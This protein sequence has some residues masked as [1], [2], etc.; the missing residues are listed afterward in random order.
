MIE[1]LIEFMRR[2]PGMVARLL[3][4]HEPD[5]AGRCRGCRQ[6]DRMTPAHPCPIRLHAQAARDVDRAL[7]D[8]GA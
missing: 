6:H 3:A 4:R 5:P 8:A 1:P 7:G 2:Q